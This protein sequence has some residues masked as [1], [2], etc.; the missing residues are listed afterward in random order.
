MGS[1][2]AAKM[3]VSLMSKAK[4]QNQNT[5]N[6]F[7]AVKEDDKFY[8]VYYVKQIVS[9]NLHHTIWKKSSGKN[10]NLFVFADVWEQPWVTA[11]PVSIS[12]L[13]TKKSQEEACKFLGLPNSINDCKSVK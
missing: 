8:L 1:P 3:L 12:Q 10:K 4:N 11:S 7:K 5:S 2:E 13:V 6:A 9:G